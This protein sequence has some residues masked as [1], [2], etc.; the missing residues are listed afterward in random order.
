MKN[1]SKKKWHPLVDKNQKHY[2]DKDKKTTIEKFEEK[3][4][5]VQLY[6]WAIITVDKYSER[7]GKKDGE[8]GEEK[9]KVKLKNY[10][11]YAKMLKDIMTTYP[12]LKNKSA[13]KVYEILDEEWRYT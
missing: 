13:K 7:M 8:K 2:I 11:E 4:T 3:Y 5:I 1:S 10:T 9:D 12:G 6:N